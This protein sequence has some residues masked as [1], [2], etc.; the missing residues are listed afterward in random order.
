MGR[1]HKTYVRTTR[2]DLGRYPT[3]PI[4][5]R[6]QLGKIGCFHGKTASF[7]WQT[8]LGRLGISCREN[9]I[10]PLTQEEMYM[11]EDSVSFRFSANTG[12]EITKVNFDFKKSR[13]IVTQGFRMGLKQLDV[14]DLREKLVEGIT[15]HNLKWDY[16]W[17]IISEI[18][19]AEG[20][21][22]LISGPRKSSSELSASSKDISSS[23]NI[24][25]VNLGVELTAAENMAYQ[26]VAK[27][28]VQPYFQIHRLTEKHQL[29]VYG[30]KSLW[31][32]IS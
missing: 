23:F 18:W 22:T 16:N 11:S 24:A 6:N 13:S 4:G 15:K 8:D 30:K 10:R 31:E 5:Q 12:G 17:V 19:Q 20:F 9:E 14:V 32:Y 28:D 26:A 2:D 27:Q 29:K 7:D 21:T 3:W 25:D 1:I